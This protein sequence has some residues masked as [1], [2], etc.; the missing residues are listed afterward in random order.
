MEMRRTSGEK[1]RIEKER[2]YIL[3]ETSL[4]LTSCL[5]CLP[6]SHFCSNSSLFSDLFPDV[7]SGDDFNLFLGAASG[8]TSPH[9]PFLTF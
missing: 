9:P 8:A 6:S 3:Q 5:L 4:S 1:K 2:E 7:K